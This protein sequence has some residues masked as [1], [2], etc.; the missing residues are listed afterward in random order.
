M[1]L[2]KVVIN[3]YLK[4]K[5]LHKLSIKAILLFLFNESLIGFE[6]ELES[7]HATFKEQ[8]TNNEKLKKM[9]VIQKFSLRTQ[10]KIVS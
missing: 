9:K 1:L 4:I 5:K 3:V 7:L 2:E 6:Q 8:T 10:M